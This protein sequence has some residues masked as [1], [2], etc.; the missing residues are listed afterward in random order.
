MIRVSAAV[1]VL[2][3]FVLLAV[4]KADPGD[5]L[6]RKPRRTYIRRILKENKDYTDREYIGRVYLF[7]EN[8]VVSL[9][10]VGADQYPFN[11]FVIDPHTGYIRVTQVLDREFISLYSFTI[12]IRYTN[13]TILEEWEGFNFWI[14]DENDNAPVFGDIQPGEVDEL[15]PE[16]TFVMKVTATD[17]DEP[18][19]YNS[20]IA[21]T[22]IDQNPPD[23]RFYINREDGSIYA[24]KPLLEREKCDQYIL[25]VRGQDLDGRPGGNSGTANVTINIRDVN[26]HLPTLDKELY[27]GSIEENSKGVEVMRLQAEDLDLKGTDNWEAVFDIVRGNEAGYFSITTDP[28]TNEGIL[29]LDKPVDYEDVKNLELGLAVRNKAPPFNGSETSGRVG[30][31]VNETAAGPFPGASSWQWGEK[32]KIYPVKISVKNQPEGPHFYPKVKA[33][34]IPDEGTSFNITEVIARYPAIDEDTGQ[35]A[36]NVRYAIGSDPGSWLTIDPETA[37]IKLNKI[38]DRDSLH[39]VNGIYIAEVLCITEDTP[40]KT[41]TGTIAIEVEDFNDHCPILTSDIYTICTIKDAVIVNAD[42]EDSYPNGPPFKFEITPEGTEGKWRMEHLNDTAAILR[43][44]EYMWPAIYEVEIMVKDQ[45]GKACPEQQK[46]PVRVCTCEDGVRC[47]KRGGNNQPVK[48][49]HLG[50]AGTGIIVQAVLLL[51]LCVPLVLLSC[52]CKCASRD[53]PPANNVRFKKRLAKN[54]EYNNLHASR[55]GLSPGSNLLRSGKGSKD[56]QQKQLY[57]G[58]IVTV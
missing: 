4:L 51:L 18:G 54:V 37:E 25:T 3:L 16:G 20:K 13:G 23:D 12:V 1:F 35:L 2:L 49:V 34:P 24:K 48:G 43:A 5:R 26:N 30:G 17:A 41:A 55:E 47:G 42:D 45:Q 8:V 29:M 44:Q 52:Q 14:G 32:S 33:I 28:S 6:L 15:S 9:K 36:A 50:P 31:R 11:V 10:G 57:V 27:E 56:V 53:V 38:P 7:Y 22:I 21:Y 46:I 58:D 39:L 19:N 40:P